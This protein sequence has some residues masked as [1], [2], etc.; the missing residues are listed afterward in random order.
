MLSELDKMCPVQFIEGRNKFAEPAKASD[1]STEA[2]L[3]YVPKVSHSVARIDIFIG[4]STKIRANQNNRFVIFAD[5]L[6]H[7]T[8]IIL[9]EG[10][11][12]FEKGEKPSAD[13]RT[14]EIT[15][16]VV[17]ISHKR[18]WLQFP[19]SKTKFVYYIGSKG[20]QIVTKYKLNAKWE[21]KSNVLMLRFY[22]RILPLAYV[23]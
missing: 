6:D 7:P 1:I 20:D 4:W 22:G 12:S 13:W 15:Q 14:I 18:Y 11:M 23:H 9:T 16:P 8:D 10:N 21:T 17:L 19:D 2:Y 5:Y 3:E